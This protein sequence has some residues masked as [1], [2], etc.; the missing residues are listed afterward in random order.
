MTKKTEGYQIE[1][2]L[3]TYEHHN[4][5]PKT[6]VGV[7]GYTLP[8]REEISVSQTRLHMAADELLNKALQMTHAIIPA[9]LAEPIDGTQLSLKQLETALELTKHTDPSRSKIE[10]WSRD[11]DSKT[12][13]ITFKIQD[14]TKESEDG[15]G[16]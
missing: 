3:V 12:K 8:P 11:L 5:P 7:S 4:V 10:V 6:F 2:R 13:L 16:L 1:M 9:E 15:N 14:I